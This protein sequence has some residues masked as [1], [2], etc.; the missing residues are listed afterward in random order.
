VLILGADTR[1][2]L[3][4]VRSLGRYGLEVDVAWCPWNSPSLR[5]RY[6]RKVHALPEYRCDDTAWIRALVE[7]LERE[8]YDLVIGCN[9]ACLLPLQQHRVEIEPAGRLDLLPDET[10]D[11]CFDKRKT[12]DLAERLGIPVPRQR[13]IHSGAELEALAAEWGYP[14][15]LKPRASV[16]LRDPSSK[17]YVTKVWAPADIAPALRDFD[18]AQGV[19][20][21]ENFTGRGAGVEVLAK[22]GEVLTAFQHERVHEPLMGG[23]GSY[24]KSVALDPAL[25][26]AT[27]RLMRALSY[28]GVAMVEFKRNRQ[29]GAWA[30][31]EINSRFWGSLPLSLA[32]GIDFPRYLYEMVTTG[33]AEFPKTYREGIYAR[34][35]V[36]DLYWLKANLKAD[37]SNPALMTLPLG[38]VAREIFHLVTL[39]ETSDTLVLDDPAP[40][41]SEI[42]QLLGGLLTARLRR[43]PTVRGE[44]RRRAERAIGRAR[45]ILFLCRGN[46]CRSPFA[47]YALRL[48]AGE[49]VECASAGS[50]PVAGRRSPEAAIEAAGRLGV[51]LGPHRSRVLDREMAA[52]AD[53]I[54]I[55][56][57]GQEST[58]EAWHPEA[59]G[60]VHYLGALDPEG[61]LE[62][63]DP[64]GSDAGDFLA[65]YRRLEQLL[66][67][68]AFQRPTAS[69]GE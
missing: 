64:Y 47:E 62:I 32:A 55:F 2:F 49:A 16:S 9:D 5:S 53:V 42:R 33:R 31:M 21:Q 46:I 57:R 6:I 10:F 44:M 8:R 12:Y 24:R 26:D 39:R 35:W 60:K 50:F 56:D 17:H 52:R 59:I 34:N 41:F 28:T 30:L 18:L 11:I 14:L 19:P 40:A 63:A 69:R 4:V 43:I 61:P 51:D 25:L 23:G 66:A 67:L 37:R 48:S 54:L 22:D 15:V 36:M 45:R 27:R 58:L 38:E 3:S 29:T 13:M 1:A 65:S 7:L 68:P 20:V